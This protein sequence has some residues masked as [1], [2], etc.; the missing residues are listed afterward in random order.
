M[1]ERGTMMTRNIVRRGVTAWLSPH[2]QSCGSW[3]MHSYPFTKIV[4]DGNDAQSYQYM[5]QNDAPGRNLLRAGHPRA[6]DR[7]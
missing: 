1:T 5:F 2:H 7:Q 3:E 4:R 6:Q